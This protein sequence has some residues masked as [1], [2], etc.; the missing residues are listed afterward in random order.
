[1][2]KLEVYRQAVCEVLSEYG[3]YKP[4]NAE[5]EVQTIFDTE[6]DHYQIVSVG[7]QDNRRVHTC[8]IHIDI[9]PEC[10]VW[11]QLNNTD[12]QLADELMEHGVA[13]E[14]IV[15]GFHSA[16][17]RQFTEFAKG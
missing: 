7:W 17:M 2:A 14:D 16:Y 8:T 10:K 4:V 13:R 9:K 3:N 15:L 11:I 6:R 12:L 5:V 1:M